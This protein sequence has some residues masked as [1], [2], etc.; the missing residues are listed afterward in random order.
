MAWRK[1][2]DTDRTTTKKRPARHHWPSHSWGHQTWLLANWQRGWNV[3]TS[4]LFSE[5]LNISKYFF[6]IF[7]LEVEKVIARDHMFSTGG[8]TW[9]MFIYLC[10]YMF[11]IFTYLHMICRCM[12]KYLY[13]VI[14]IYI[15]INTYISIWLHPGSLLLLAWNLSVL[16]PCELW[17][18]NDCWK[19]KHGN[20]PL[21]CPEW[22]C[23]ARSSSQN[24]SFIDVR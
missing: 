1:R 8:A 22:F 23:C 11:R 2:M 17:A 24:S 13:V 21:L 20:R 5:H 7:Q 3:G 6:N 15:Y 14:Y 4:Q 19:K 9:S 18:V 12:Y 10:I 16:R